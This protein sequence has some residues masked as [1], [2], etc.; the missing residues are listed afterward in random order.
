MNKG[1]DKKKGQKRIVVV[2]CGGWYVGWLWWW[3]G[4]GWLVGVSGNI[5]V[6]S[7]SNY[8][9]Q[10]NGLTVV[11]HTFNRDIRKIAIK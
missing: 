11:K 3:G 8:S 5:L 10:A 1:I 4:E 7:Q 6:K 9:T 2:V